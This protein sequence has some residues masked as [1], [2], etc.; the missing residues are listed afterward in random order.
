MTPSGEAVAVWRHFFQEEAKGYYA[1]QASYRHPGGSFSSP[2]D[3]AV[4]PSTALPQDIHVA[5]DAA[6]DTA[7]IWIQQE[8]ESSSA[9]VASIRPAS[10]EFSTPEAISPP[11]RLGGLR[12]LP[13]RRDRRHRRS[14][15]RLGL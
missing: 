7:V 13:P 10:G 2:L 4:T 1:I 14:D 8:P 12:E 15:R 9:V 5:I 11:A 6:G 3:V